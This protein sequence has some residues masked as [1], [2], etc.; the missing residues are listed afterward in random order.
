MNLENHG[1]FR[2]ALADLRRNLSCFFFFSSI[3]VQTSGSGISNLLAVATTFTG[4]GNLYCQWEHLTWQWE[5]LVHFIPN[6]EQDRQGSHK[7]N[8]KA[9][10]V[11]DEET[12]KAELIRRKRKGRHGYMLQ[13]MRKSLKPRHDMNTIVKKFE[14]TLKE[15]VPK[16]VNHIMDQNMQDNLPWLMEKAYKFEKP[17]VHVE[18]CRID[19][20]CRQDYDDHYDDDAHLEGESSAKRS[21]V[22]W[23]RVHDYQLIL[24]SYQIKVNVTAPKLTFSGIEEKTPYTIIT[25]PLVGLIYEYIKKERRVMDIDEI[26]KFYDATLKR[27]LEKVKKINLDVKNGYADPILNDQDAKL[28]K[29]YE[30]HI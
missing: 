18:P 27:V 30:A 22:I 24:E 20:F 17:T 5:C 4:R 13:H 19:A 11:S 23:E 3:A 9:E 8:P 10:R 2:G 14:E 6:T 25:H 15:V 28:I 29:F 16:M 7:E 1:R 12:A 26:P 21:N